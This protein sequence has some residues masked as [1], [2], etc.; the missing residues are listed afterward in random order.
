MS[1]GV[2]ER[3]KWIAR[4]WVVGQTVLILAFLLLPYPDRNLLPA[5]IRSGGGVLLF[6]VSFVLGIRGFMEIGRQLTPLPLPRPGASLVRT[7]VFRLVRHPVYAAV[8]LGFA[9]WAV[10]AGNWLHGLGAVAIFLF[11]DAKARWEEARLVEI[12]PEYDAY[13]RTTRRFFP[14]IY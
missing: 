4:A 14:G 3:N 10:L 7:G 8:I 11:F 1:L 6:C 2:E 12:F 13:R 5:P 9:G